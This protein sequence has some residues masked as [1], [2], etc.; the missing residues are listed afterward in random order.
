MF[1]ALGVGAWAAAIY[2]FATHAFFKS[3]LFLGAGVLI[4]MLNGEHDI[5][6]MGS[7]RH[8]LPATYIAFLFA[9]LTLA[10]VPPL[11]LTF[12]SKDL[13]LNQAFLS[14]GVGKALW[15]LG[16]A[17][18]FLTALYTFRL[19]FVAFSGPERAVPR[20][21]PSRW[22]LV[23]FAVLTFLGAIAGLPDLLRALFGMN[24]FYVFLNSALPGP[25]RDFPSTRSV[26]AFQGIYVATALAGIALAYL[27]YERAP[28]YVEAAVSTPPGR[29]LHRWWFAD[30]GFDWLYQKLF[31][32][33][34]IVLARLDRD[35]FV[36]AIYVVVARVSQ[37]LNYLLSLTVSGNVRWYVAAIAGGA[38]FVIG[39]VVLL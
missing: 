30:W 32:R 15:A 11:S 24:E 13:I 16:W 37:A 31:I 38:V 2:H 28:R 21:S 6:K 26:W 29:L 4:K 33:P 39:L 23:P 25:A 5:F 17:G 1:L 22:M 9:A 18:T 19:V 12:N 27:L 3:A 36:D 20:A 7:L 8:R 14:Q 35:D 34:Y 10:A